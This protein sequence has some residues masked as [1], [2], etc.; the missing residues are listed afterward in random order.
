MPPSLI[1]T[2]TSPQG[3]RSVQIGDCKTTFLVSK[4][5]TGGLYCVVKHD[6][7]PGFPGPAPHAHQVTTHTFY[8]IQGTVNIVLD[9]RVV[10]AT[11][12]TSVYIPTGVVHGFSNPGQE[13]ACMLEIDMPGSFQ[14]YFEALGRAFVPGEPI[15]QVRMAR[16]Q[17]QFDFVAVQ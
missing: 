16:L 8:I 2:S 7:P 10:E 6:L 11:E 4:A 9:R 13:Q 15:D 14:D 12:G 1:A 3:G 5:D 17:Q